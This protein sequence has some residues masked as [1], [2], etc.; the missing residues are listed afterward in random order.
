MRRIHLVLAILL[1]A[2][3]SAS[4][5]ESWYSVYR[6]DHRNWTA[7]V[8]GGFAFMG[9][10]GDTTIDDSLGDTNVSLDGVLDL[11][12]IETFWV[13]AD[14][15]LFRG[16]HFRLGYTPLTFDGSDTLATAIQIDGQTYD[17]GDLVDSELELDQY[18]LSV[19]WDFYLTE[20]VTVS[21]VMQVTLVDAAVNV[22]NETAALSVTED[23]LL[24]IPCLGVKGE[25]YPFTRLGLFAEGKG[26]TLGSLATTWELQGGMTLHLT[27]NVALQGK[28]RYLDYSFDF[29]DTELDLNLGGAY[30]GTTVR[31]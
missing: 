12:E 30:V 3:T 7:A 27:R 4:A 22:S 19:L 8:S 20:F 14:V 15:Q 6:P 16:K 21:P 18:E 10:D 9:L 25:V 23:Q 29:S 5:G 26:M 28:Y 2:P 31:F 1:A 17:P 13:E 24:P 11:T